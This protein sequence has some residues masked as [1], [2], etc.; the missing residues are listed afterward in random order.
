MKKYSDFSL[1]N[2]TASI[3]KILCNSSCAMF[4]IL[5]CKNIGSGK[6][7]IHGECLYLILIARNVR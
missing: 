2:Y 3:F 1:K 5:A 7:L 4:D 6:I